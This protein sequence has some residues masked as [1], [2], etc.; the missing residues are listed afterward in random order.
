MNSVTLWNRDLDR[1]VGNFA[2][3]FADRLHR[4]MDSGFRSSRRR[5][6]ENDFS[7]ELDVHENENAYLMSVDLPGVT[8]DQVHIEVKENTLHLSG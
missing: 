5:V 6:E 4:D 3:N 7:P 8:K 2:G 1:L